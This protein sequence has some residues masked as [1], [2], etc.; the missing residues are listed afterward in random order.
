MQAYVSQANLVLVS[1][2]V[3]GTTYTSSANTLV[4]Q[5]PAINSSGSTISNKYDKVAFYPSGTNFYIQLEP[6]AASSRK[7]LNKILSDSLQSVTLTYDNAS[8]ALVTKVTVNFLSQLQV[9]A[10]TV[11]SNLVQNMYLLNY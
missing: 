11:Q 6:D 7:K 8:Y 5:M 4:L 9:K 10:Q 1:A 3:N 2:T